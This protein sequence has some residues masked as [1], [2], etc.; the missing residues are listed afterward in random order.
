MDRKLS[1]SANHWSLKRGDE[2]PLNMIVN[3]NIIIYYYIIIIIIDII[4][5]IV[6][7]YYY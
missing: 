2:N 1:S 6:C 4:I 7:H 5:I 3:L